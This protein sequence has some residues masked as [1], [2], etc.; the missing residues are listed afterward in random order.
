MY[1]KLLFTSI[2][3]KHK[4]TAKN[5]EIHQK[6]YYLQTNN[7]KLTNVCALFANLRQLG[8]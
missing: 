3:K 8:S 1:N 7:I 6:L 5:Y 2:C 4:K